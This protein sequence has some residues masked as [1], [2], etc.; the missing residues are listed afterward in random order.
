M[1]K[2]IVDFFK[3]GCVKNKSLFEKIDCE[4]ALKKKAKETEFQNLEYNLWT[5]AKSINEE[6]G[7][8]CKGNYGSYLID[9][10]KLNTK[11][12][13]KK[14]I[15]ITYNSDDFDRFL[16]DGELEFYIQFV[17]ST[18]DIYQRTILQKIDSEYVYKLFDSEFDFNNLSGFIVL[19][20]DKMINDTTTNYLI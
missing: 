5:L 6:F 1:L 8:N 3:F 18:G 20:K 4:L 12:D 2:W 9:S 13:K 16:I 15:Y 14:P 7:T 11:S 17:F 10:K 19:L